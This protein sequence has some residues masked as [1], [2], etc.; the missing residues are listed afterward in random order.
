MSCTLMCNSNGLWQLKFSM[1][2]LIL[3]ITAKMEWFL[4]NGVP[5]AMQVKWHTF[6]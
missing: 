5:Q 6:Y 1:Q 2:W 4:L 3:L